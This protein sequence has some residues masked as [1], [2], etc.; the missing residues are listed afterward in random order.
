MKRFFLFLLFLPA[1]FVSAQNDDHD[2][3]TIQQLDIFNHVYRELDLRY[4]DTLS[5]KK[6][7][8]NALDYMLSQLDP[9]TVYYPAEHTADLRQMATGKYAGVGAIITYRRDLDRCIFNYPYLGMPA[10]EAGVLPGDVIL[11]IDGKAFPPCGSTPPDVYSSSVSEALRGQSATTCQLLI[12][13]PGREQPIALALQRRTI[14]MPPIPLFTLVGDSIGYVLIDGFTENTARDLRRAVVDLKQQGARRL[15]LD[16][17]ENGGGLITEAVK[18]V[19]LFVPKGKEVVSTRGKISENTAVYRTESNPIDLETPL[20]VL[21]DAATASAAEITAGALQD[22]DRAVILGRRTYGKG[23]VQE[24]RPVPSGGMVKLT[25]SKYY[26]PSGRCIQAYKY[27]DGEPVHQPD[28]LST[29]FHTAGGRPVRD[30]GGITPDVVTPLDS[31]PNLVLYLVA[32][33]QLHDFCA[34]YRRT[35][36]ALPA[37]DTFALTDSEYQRLCTFLREHKFTYDSQSRRALEL[38]RHVAAREGYTDVA[39][40]EFEALEQKLTHNEAYDFQHW[41]AQIAR[42]AEQMLVHFYYGDEGEARYRL[43]G[44]TD[45]QQALTLLQDPERYRALLRPATA[46]SPSTNGQ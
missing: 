25:V 29:L 18:V 42:T 15:V 6:N 40:P 23:L 10:A 38:L 35:H 3:A 43:R 37:P 8:E 30:G 28:S 27:E 9:Y 14:V 1:L 32:S 12:Q 5:A 17:R 36:A 34:D 39:R 45:L 4:V 11:S 41:R 16:L 33:D 13:R 2:A 22:Y 44:D 31:L 21:T 46:D 24:S 7:V 19:S 20:V 26:I